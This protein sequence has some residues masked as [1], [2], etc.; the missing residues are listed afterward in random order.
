MALRIRAVQA[1]SDDA[2]AEEE[3]KALGPLSGLA[4]EDLALPAPS[5]T[6]AAPSSVATF[7]HAREVFK[8]GTAYATRAKATFVL[9]G[10]VTSHFDVLQLEAELYAQLAPWESDLPRRSRCT[11]DG[12]PCYSRRSRS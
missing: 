7:E 6:C 1:S 3:G 4:F 5:K 10:Y 9:D 12:S 8:K 11:S 2:S